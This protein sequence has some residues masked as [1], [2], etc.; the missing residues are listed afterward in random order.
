MLSESLLNECVCASYSFMP[1][2]GWA[3]FDEWKHIICNIYHILLSKSLFATDLFSLVF[4]EFHLIRHTPASIRIG[5]GL[6]SVVISSVVWAEKH[7]Y[8]KFVQE[9]SWEQKAGSWVFLIPKTLE[10]MAPNLTTYR[11]RG[12]HFIYTLF[13]LLC[14]NG[15]FSCLLIFQCL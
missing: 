3:I 9:S 1:D 6:F 4:L 14:Q 5:L 10:A 8:P 2:I 15:K 7:Q 11:L 12:H 13:I